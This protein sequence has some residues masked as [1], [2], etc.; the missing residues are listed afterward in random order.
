LLSIGCWNP[1]DCKFVF[2]AGGPATN[3][4]LINVLPV[5]DKPV[6]DMISDALLLL[7]VQIASVVVPVVLAALAVLAEQTGLAVLV[8]GLLVADRPGGVLVG[9]SCLGDQIGAGS[10]V[11]PEDAAAQETEAEQEPDGPSEHR[12]ERLKAARGIGIQ[13]EQ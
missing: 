7:V 13:Q 9:G 10:L 1:V 4:W 12:D 11:A 2:A 3:G 6:S 8:A 5:R